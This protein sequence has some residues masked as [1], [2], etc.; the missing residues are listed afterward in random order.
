MT[1]LKT[2]LF[3]W[4]GHRCQIIRGS[5]HFIRSS[6]HVHAYTHAI[7]HA[8]M[9]ACTRTHAHT[10]THTNNFILQF[11]LPWKFSKDPSN[12]EWLDGIVS[13]LTSS[14]GWLQSSIAYHTCIGGVVGSRK[15]KVYTFHCF[16]TLVSTWVITEAPN[17]V[18]N[19]LDDSHNLEFR[20]LATWLKCVMCMWEWAFHMYM[21]LR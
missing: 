9:H 17:L 18:N 4:F 11:F 6:T 1:L 12:E 5:D 21:H 7:V 8:H 10:Q 13:I 3:L 2:R 14:R 16:L 19:C 20:W 15:Y